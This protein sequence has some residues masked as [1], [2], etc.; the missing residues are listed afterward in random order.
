ML[1]CICKADKDEIAAAYLNIHPDLI[2]GALIRFGEDVC[3][4]AFINCAGKQISQREVII[5]EIPAF[6]FAFVTAKRA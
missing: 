4:A 1:Y 3:D 2:K 6:G 5:D